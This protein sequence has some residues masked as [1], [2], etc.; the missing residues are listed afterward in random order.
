MIELFKTATTLGPQHQHLTELSSFSPN[1]QHN[2]TQLL[3]VCSVKIIRHLRVFGSY[4]RGPRIA[5]V[6]V[7]LAAGHCQCQ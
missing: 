5:I 4:T 3:T 7:R 2:A 1:T 6:Y